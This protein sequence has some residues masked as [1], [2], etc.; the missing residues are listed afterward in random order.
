MSVTQDTQPEGIFNETHSTSKLMQNQYPQ[1][2]LK[3]WTHPH[4]N[5]PKHVCLRAIVGRISLALSEKAACPA[6]IH[7]AQLLNIPVVSFAASML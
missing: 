6:H 7:P 3:L 4:Q 5:P 2:H 1:K